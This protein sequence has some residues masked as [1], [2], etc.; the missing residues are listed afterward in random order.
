MIGINP[1]VDDR[2]HNIAAVGYDIPRLDHL[3][4][5]VIIKVVDLFHQGIIRHRRRLDRVI[6]LRKF[7][8]R[9]RLKHLKKPVRLLGLRLDP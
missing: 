8:I 7:D 5:F 6:R 3:A 1:A 4:H 9:I 2:H